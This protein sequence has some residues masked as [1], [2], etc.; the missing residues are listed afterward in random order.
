MNLKMA[1]DRL[2][3]SIKQL[4][5]SEPTIEYRYVQGEKLEHI[6]SCPQWA[7]AW[8]RQSA[9]PMLLDVLKG[10]LLQFAG[11]PFELEPLVKSLEEATSLT[12]AEIRVATV[13]LR[14]SGILHAV[15]KAWG[16]QLI[17]L[18]TDCIPMW[19]SLLL[20]VTGLP[21][22]DEESRE[23]AVNST[24]YR[25]PLSLELLSAWYEIKCRPIAF[26][27]KGTLHRPAVIRM[28]AAMRLMPEELSCLSLNYPQNEQ[29]PAQA[30]LALDLGLC[31]KVLHK[32]GNEIRISDDGLKEWLTLTPAEAD[33]RLHELVISRYG[34]AQPSLH[35]IASAVR[36]LNPMTWYREESLMNIGTR[37]Q[38]EAVNDWLGLLES[39]GWVERGTCLGTA[40]FRIKIHLAANTSAIVQPSGA[41]FV[42]PDG[43]IFVTP[44]T[45][46]MQRWVLEEISE[47]AVA[48]NLF[49]YRLTLNACIR[50]YN[51][52]Y[53]L[54]SVIAFLEQGYG[55]AL[56]EQVTRALQ[57]WFSPLGKVTFAEVTLLRI[58][59]PDVAAQLMKDPDI[60]VK[61]LEQLGDRD[62]IIEKSSYKFLYDRMAKAGFPP[63]ETYRSAPGSHAAENKE[64]EEQGWIYR[65]HVLS[66]YEADRTLPGKDELFPGMLKIPAAWIS[67][68]RNYHAS[69]RKELLQRA[70]D[71]QASVRIGREGQTR[72]FV[73]K[74]FEEE[75]SNWCVL[76]RWRENP[77]IGERRNGSTIAAV[78]AEEIAEIM[79]LLPA[80]EELETN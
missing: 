24:D 72:T 8:I 47:R 37:V 76:G 25:L 78:S 1:V 34:S 19:Q 36:S 16:D 29:L 73:P 17:Y 11:Q 58:D 53:T 20:P 62:F 57:D 9:D 51:N 2:S 30:A 42:Q 66:V 6:L 79:I 50:A 46:L 52:G 71:W 32:A 35:L 56:P 14:R 40:V 43:E 39:L 54:H 63:T 10:I 26:T 45:G 21:L 67:S 3:D 41:L 7:E 68:P 49:V 27:A 61:L 12:G 22:T 4:V 28:T 44:E 31:S 74:G 23:A 18:P 64:D 59:N 77:E 15:R 60:A 13:R 5:L 33:I 55:S 69:T 38:V 65:R 80:F 70:I 75:G 48:D